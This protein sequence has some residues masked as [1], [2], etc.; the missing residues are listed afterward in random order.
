MISLCREASNLV[1]K[2][3]PWQYVRLTREEEAKE[4]CYGLSIELWRPELH[5][6]VIHFT[7]GNLVLVER[8]VPIFLLNLAITCRSFFTAPLFSSHSWKSTWMK[9]SVPIP[10]AFCLQNFSPRGW[11]GPF[12]F[13]SLILRE[14]FSFIFAFMNLSWLKQ[15]TKRS[16]F[17]N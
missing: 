3:G 12:F 7:R 4:L 9:L 2:T 15:A 5:Y 11:C 17:I 8:I 13:I 1:G 10:N 16:S 14:K 6:G